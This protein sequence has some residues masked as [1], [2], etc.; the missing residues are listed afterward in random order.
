MSAKVVIQDAMTNVKTGVLGVLDVVRFALELALQ[1]AQG[2][3][4]TLYVKGHARVV[5]MPSVRHPVKRDV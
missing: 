2:D 1:G 3:A 5:V 4:Q